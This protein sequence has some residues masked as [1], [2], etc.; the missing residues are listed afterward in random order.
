MVGVDYLGEA[1]SRESHGWPNGLFDICMFEKPRAAYHRAMW[2]NKPLVSI[3]FLDPSLDIDHGRDLW[4]WPKMAS[5]W[6]L[7]RTYFGQVIQVCTKKQLTLRIILLYGIFLIV[8]ELWKQRD[9]MMGK[10]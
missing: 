4:Q 2:N 1:A 10:K 7:P 6:N 3:A 8:R 5:H 9:I